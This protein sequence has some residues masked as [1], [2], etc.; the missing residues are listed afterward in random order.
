M[1]PK[2][3]VGVALEGASRL[4]EG[5]KVTVLL[6]LVVMALSLVVALV[7]A[8]GR[9]SRHA[10]LRWPILG[11]IEVT[12]NTPLL[13]QLYYVY[14]VLPYVGIRIDPFPAAVMAL[15]LNYS[16]YMS[17]VYRSGIQAIGK[18]QHDAA[19]A[20]GMTLFQK[21]RRIVLP[22]AFRIVIP[23]L[24]NYFISL[25]K[26]TA[27]CSTISAAE[28]MFAARTITA[29]NYQYFT[30]YTTVFVLYFIVGFPAARLVGHL[31][32]RM[33]RGYSRRRKPVHA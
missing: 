13:L 5:L 12:R 31:E 17:E 22:Q 29:V 1:L 11:Y 18:G 21:F 8:M 15:T 9:M 26:D 16:A 28:V 4:L 14:F 23:G 25:F 6:T 7:V 33:K 10:A 30:I 32:R 20:L 3:D 27:L 19:E 24:G 2:F